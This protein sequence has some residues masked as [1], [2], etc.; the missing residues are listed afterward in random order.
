MDSWKAPPGLVLF[1]KQADPNFKALSKLSGK[2]SR[3][4]YVSILR[5][6]SRLDDVVFQSMDDPL[7]LFK[8]LTSIFIDTNPTDSDLV[9]AMK[10]GSGTKKTPFI[11]INLDKPLL[12]LISRLA[13]VV[14][15]SQVE[16][17]LSDCC[18]ITSKQKQQLEHP[19]MLSNQH[20]W[21]M[22]RFVSV[23]ESKLCTAID[24]MSHSVI[25]SILE[26]FKEFLDTTLYSIQK[27]V[28]VS[29]DLPL[30]MLGMIVQQLSAKR[31][32][33]IGS[34]N[35]DIGL[36][37]AGIFAQMLSVEGLHKDCVTKTALGMVLSLEYSGTDFQT[38]LHAFLFQCGQHALFPAQL[39]VLPRMALHRSILRFCSPSLFYSDILLHTLTHCESSSSSL[40]LYAIQTLTTFVSSLLSNIE[41]CSEHINMEETSALILSTI[42]INWDHRFNVVSKALKPLFEKYLC[43]YEHLSSTSSSV[44][45]ISL[46]KQ[47]LSLHEDKQDINPT[48]SSSSQ[49][50]LIAALLPKLKATGSVSELQSTCP[51]LLTQLFHSVTN[52][53]LCN[54]AN[55]LLHSLLTALRCEMEDIQKWRMLWIEPLVQCMK[56]RTSQSSLESLVLPGLL[57]SDPEVIPILLN[58][59]DISLQTFIIILQK[60]KSLALYDPLQSAQSMLKI[61]LALESC[62]D[63]CRL[64]ALDLLIS[65]KQTTMPLS[66]VEYGLLYRYMPHF[67]KLQEQ[68]IRDRFLHLLKSLLRRISDSVGKHGNTEESVEFLHK[69]GRMLIQ[70]L[71]PGVPIERIGVL[72]EAL[73]LFIK[74][75]RN[76]QAGKQLGTKLWNARERI[77]ACLVTSWDRIRHLGAII[78]EN[79]A[80]P[81]PM[82]DDDI[83]ELQTTMEWALQ[84]AQRS[85]LRDAE[86]GAYLY[87]SVQSLLKSSIGTDDICTLM[88]RNM[89]RN[90]PI[91][92]LVIILRISLKCYVQDSENVVRT[93]LFLLNELNKRDPT[94]EEDCRG[95]FLEEDQLQTSNIWLGTKECS[96][97]LSAYVL[98]TQKQVHESTVREIGTVFLNILLS[99]KHNGI[100][101]KLHLSLQTVVECVLTQIR[102]SHIANDWL[103]RLLSIVKGE[104]DERRSNSWIRRSAGLPFGFLAILHGEPCKT[105]RVLLSSTMSAL[106]DILE[107]KEVTS[108]DT[109]R[110]VHALNV[111]RA[112]VRDSDFAVNMIKHVPRALQVVIHG[113]SHHSWAIRNSCLMTFSALLQLILPHNASKNALQ[114][115]TQFPLEEFI[116]EQIAANARGD[117]SA[118]ALFPLLLLLSRLSPSTT[119]NTPT[120]SLISLQQTLYSL[121]T[122]PSKLSSTCQYPIRRIGVQAYLR[123]CPQHEYSS[124]LLS[125]LQTNECGSSLS[126]SNYNVIHA[127]L[128]LM[129]GL[130]AHT[131]TDEMVI[132]DFLWNY[133]SSTS[134]PP[135]IVEA[136]I[137]IL[138]EL[139]STLRDQNRLLVLLLELVIRFRD[140]CHSKQLPGHISTLS[141][142]LRAFLHLCLTIPETQFESLQLHKIIEE[143]GDILFANCFVQ[144]LVEILSSHPNKGFEK[145]IHLE[146]VRSL[147]TKYLSLPFDPLMRYP[148]WL[149]LAQYLTIPVQVLL[150]LLSCS[151]VVS[152]QIAALQLIPPTLEELGG[153]EKLTCSDKE[154][155]MDCVDEF[156]K[157]AQPL[158]LRTAAY[159]SLI[160]SG[161]NCEGHLP[162]LFL[163]G[164]QDESREIREL[165]TSL[166]DNSIEDEQPSKA[167]ERYFNKPN[168]SFVNQLLHLWN[169]LQ[170]PMELPREG[171]MAQRD[172][173]L[174]QREK[175]NEFV[176]PLL[177]FQYK[178]LQMIKFADIQNSSQDFDNISQIET[179]IGSIVEATEQAGKQVFLSTVGFEVIY[180][181][182]LGLCVFKSSFTPQTYRIT[183]LLVRL[184][185]IVPA[186]GHLY[187]LLVLLLSKE[188]ISQSSL[189]P[190]LFLTTEIPQ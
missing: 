53:S 152:H 87:T 66:S 97:F 117:T 127:Q 120:P 40:R 81:L 165:A 123:I 26:L 174:F 160:G 158:S 65:S 35:S 36:V 171:D 143:G 8:I 77:F 189:Q 2:S 124:L 181:R 116:S 72:F 164:V 20:I 131:N 74:V 18:I 28:S 39:A 172:V 135:L 84:L 148:L 69:L 166:M 78:V 93:V 128:L 43:L 114:F 104:E 11:S 75:F 45:L 121:L 32:W 100:I 179:V 1:A 188:P 24:T 140:T 113:F 42:F 147:V 103:N 34:D 50:E 95:H 60:A 142:A 89:S 13:I 119:T 3:K 71:Y 107:Q 73:V 102:L 186:H 5:E 91:H 58:R 33:F 56:H 31:S 170:S 156:S 136:S 145:N 19:E 110:K 70:P 157:Y 80:L 182:L 161:I 159:K 146:G 111:M 52:P 67:L 37:M 61:Q 94:L 176:E 108:E 29:H 129:K 169:E 22:S 76:K 55:R 63:F 41:V 180:R 132:P 153:E 125:L 4:E 134:S 83:S 98:S 12:A 62:N 38:E 57:K 155:F 137:S 82:S 96:S 85:R 184:K 44:S 14:P 190:L 126:N 144:A 64:G 25:T 79:M 177:C 151:S 90:E 16:E 150:K 48:N 175:D 139:V 141:T 105:N 167:M 138:S 23:L 133:V 162:H 10:T 101:Q 68:N 46:A 112:L 15:K 130:I 149:T 178:C 187:D 185:D 47:I 109:T 154:I 54:S 6:T 183:S 86:S 173:Q 30:R 163:R 106:L 88:K 168:V 99:S 59:T 49:Y 17:F 27:H 115:F 118:F 21:A 7:V 92:G 9:M 51:T 122:T